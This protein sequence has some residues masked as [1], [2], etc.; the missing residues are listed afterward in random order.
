MTRERV[1]RRTHE[2]FH[3]KFLDIDYV[4]PLFALGFRPRTS[5]RI[6]P[7]W[8]ADRPRYGDWP[9]D[10]VLTSMHVYLALAVF[11]RKACSADRGVAVPSDDDLAAEASKCRERALW[12]LDAVQNHLDALSPAGRDFVARSRSMVGELDHTL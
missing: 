6:T 7:A 11:L 12:L 4:H 10:R 1:K 8:H 2:A 9:T 5:R 3:L